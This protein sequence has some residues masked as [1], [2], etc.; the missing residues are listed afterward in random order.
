MAEGNG[1]HYTKEGFSN[2]LQLR[3]NLNKGI[4]EELKGLYPN[5]IPVDRPL[6]PERNI[7]PE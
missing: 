4:S 7:S 2:I 6:V 5:L 1:Y 3:Y